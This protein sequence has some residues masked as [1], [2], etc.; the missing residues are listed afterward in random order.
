M[1]SGLVKQVPFISLDHDYFLWGHLKNLVARISEAVANVHKIP[2]IFEC[3]RQLLHRRGQAC[4]ATTE[5]NFEQLLCTIHLSAILEIKTL[6]FL[7][8]VI[9]P[10][11]A[12]IFYFI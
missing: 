12:L 9:S 5:R 2:D 4:I 7:S 10:V 8:S 11:C 6:F 3:V 1:L